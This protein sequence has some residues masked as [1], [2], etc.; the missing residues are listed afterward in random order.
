M[1]NKKPKEFFYDAWF[2]IEKM[3]CFLYAGMDLGYSLHDTWNLM[4]TSK[5]GKG[6]LNEEYIYVIRQEGMPSFNEA[7]EEY[8]CKKTVKQIKRY[9]LAD[10]RLLAEFIELITETYQLPYEDIFTKMTID[11]FME[12]CAIILGNYDFR[13]YEEY[14]K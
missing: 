14:L 2:K 4:L 6:I 11:E 3:A 1:K 8:G 13:L 7:L 9:R 10:L 5:Q 12:T